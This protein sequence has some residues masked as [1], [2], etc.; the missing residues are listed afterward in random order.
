MDITK[1]LINNYKGAV[2]TL[3]GDDYEGLTWLD[4]AAKPL[5]KTLEDLWQKT[6]DDENNLI[7]KANTDKA[8]LLDKLGITADE[9]QTLLS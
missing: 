1:I 2:W 7:V 9:L 6:L 5:K 8:A 4:N 3:D